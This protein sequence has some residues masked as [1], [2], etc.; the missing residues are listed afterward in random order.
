MHPVHT[1]AHEAHTGPRGDRTG[2]FTRLQRALLHQWTASGYLLIFSGLFCGLL[3][4]LGLDAGIGLAMSLIALAPVVL[5]MIGAAARR[6]RLASSCSFVGFAI[7]ALSALLT[8]ATLLGPLDGYP[9]LEQL[10][11]SAAGAMCAAL[12]ALTAVSS[13]EAARALWGVPRLPVNLGLAAR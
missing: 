8:V 4:A 12:V 11:R 2:P 13:W 9:L 6:Y 3:I 7:C 10:A 1:E 5:S